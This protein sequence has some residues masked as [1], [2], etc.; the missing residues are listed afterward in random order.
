[1]ILAKS[2]SQNSMTYKRKFF[3]ILR[4]NFRVFI[5]NFGVILK[6]NKKHESS[7]R[8]ISLF[9]GCGGMD[10][11]FQREGYKIVFANDIESSVKD[12]YETNLRHEIKIEDIRN[13]NKS[14][15]PQAEIVIAGIPC[16]PFSNAGNRQ[17][18]KDTD[19]NL[20]LQ[21]LEVITSQPKRPKVVVFENVRG[22]LSSRDENGIL[23]TDRFSAE[24]R[25]LGYSTFFKLLN[26]ADF[27]VP[28][29][30][31]RV[32][33]VCVLTELQKD[34][35]F[36]ELNEKIQPKTVG[37]IINKQLPHNE[38]QEVWNLP[39]SSKRLV[40]FIPEGGSWKNIPDDKLSER[41]LKIRRNPKKYRAPN[42]YR[43]FAR[44]E[45]MGTVTATSSPENS[46]ILHPL[47][48]RRYSVREVARFQSFP[49]SF[50]FLGENV[51]AKYKMIGNAVP[52]LLAQVIAK[53]IKDQ[54]F[55]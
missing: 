6:M 44:D 47:E 55:F 35:I 30:R 23:L 36:P 42:F 2:K 39:P 5:H 46:G 52:P 28:S 25:Q 1:M 26:A 54:F 50:K 49:D 16:Q 31:Y 17:S 27:G 34:F 9:S 48:D 15:I 29:N 37:A 13:F 18:T 14:D 24:M 8:V 53:A 10:L 22:F 21:V 33:I 11:G 40:G 3:V 20:F 12:T 43:R 51:S 41:F 19:G 45:I 38:I 7:L 32:F 4:C